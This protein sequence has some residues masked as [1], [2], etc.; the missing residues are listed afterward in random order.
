MDSIK[1]TV[2]GFKREAYTG[3]NRCFACTIVNVGIAIVLSIGVAVGVAVASS[4]TGALLAA[5][6][7]FVVCAAAIYFVGYLVPGTP[8]LTKKYFPQWLLAYFGKS[9]WAVKQRGKKN[10]EPVES[11]LGHVDIEES[12]VRAGALEECQNGV[13]L[14]LDD[15]FQSAWRDQ[16]K[17]IRDEGTERERILDVLDVDED[18][19]VEFDEHGGAFEAR[20][21][22]HYIGTW[23]SQAAYLADIASGQL[24]P[25][26]HPD[27]EE[28]SSYQ[29]GGLLN[30]LRLFMNTCPSC[31]QS[32][33][34][35]SDTVESCCATREV[36]AVT[37][38]DCG[39]RVFEAP[40]PDEQDPQP[41]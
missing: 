12:L 6:A 10:E 32:L 29:R 18:V 38:D 41:A 4:L 30:G 33:S 7:T 26:W 13:D 40:I 37:C 27:W 11:G 31:D 5:G 28:F 9:Y 21:N 2:N 15:G 1:T 19:E 39:E 22:G 35:G 25:E 23:E 20:A 14:C 24:L 34:F 17:D 16:I 8:R 36:A 3:N